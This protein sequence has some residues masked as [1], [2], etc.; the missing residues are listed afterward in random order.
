VTVESPRTEPCARRWRG[1]SLTPRGPEWP[2]LLAEL[3]RQL[4]T[5]AVYARDLPAITVE[6]DA[7]LAAITRRPRPWAWFQDAR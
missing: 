7:A 4:D 1:L 3:T 6:F 5:G 2:G